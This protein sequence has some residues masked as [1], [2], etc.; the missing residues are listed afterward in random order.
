MSRRSGWDNDPVVAPTRAVVVEDFLTLLDRAL[1]GIGEIAE[2]I[3]DQQKH[4]VIL[5]NI[6]PA[7][8]LCG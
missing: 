6:R 5:G 4:A 3:A 7:R 2:I 1:I 8:A